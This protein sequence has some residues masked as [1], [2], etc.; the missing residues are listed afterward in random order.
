MKPLRMRGIHRSVIALLGLVL[1]AQPA[2]AQP[3]KDPPKKE[4]P[5]G[6]E[7]EPEIE[8]SGDDKKDKV[9]PD[10]IDM[11]AEPPPGNLEADMAAAEAN[12]VVK[13]G[14]VTRT[15]LS[16]KDIL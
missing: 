13:A 10:E 7:A 5:K 4:T 14:A 2:Y 16:W 12:T 1:A 3:K 9:D 8:M 11:G 6:G 15:P